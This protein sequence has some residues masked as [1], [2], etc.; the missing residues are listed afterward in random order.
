MTQD[1]YR[2]SKC[3]VCLATCERERIDGFEVH[4]VR[5]I[6]ERTAWKCSACGRYEITPL[7]EDAE[8]PC[9][10]C[11]ELG[12]DHCGECDTGPTLDDYRQA[13]A[14]EALDP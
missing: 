9:P 8:R 3:P 1:R 14:E 7:E 10:S 2:R 6:I 13:R 4:D 12:G 5:T 11:G